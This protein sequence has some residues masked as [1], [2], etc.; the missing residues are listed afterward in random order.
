MQTQDSLDRLYLSAGLG[1]TRCTPEGGRRGKGSLAF[2]A[3]MAAPETQNHRKGRKQ[4]DG[5]NNLG[6]SKINKT[7]QPFS[8][9]QMKSQDFFR[10]SNLSSVLTFTCAIGLQICPHRLNT[11]LNQSKV[12]F[13]CCTDFYGYEANKQIPFVQ[14]SDGCQV[15]CKSAKLETF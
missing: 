10:E 13:D 7:F 6:F 3:Q 5:T 8:Y 1:T 4:M 9:I 12:K 14:I 11:L 2:S 15:C